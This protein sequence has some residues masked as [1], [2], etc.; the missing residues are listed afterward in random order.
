MTAPEIEIVRIVL[1]GGETTL[2]VHA[3]INMFECRDFYD[4]M[5]RVVTPAGTT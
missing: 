3:I 1:R 2:R 5:F 4:S